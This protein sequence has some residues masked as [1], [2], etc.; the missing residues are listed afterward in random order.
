MALIDKS[1]NIVTCVF[2]QIMT[3]SRHTEIVLAT[4]ASQTKLFVQQGKVYCDGVLDS[5]L[6]PGL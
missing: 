3:K 4:S 5:G 6:G 1:W 2:V